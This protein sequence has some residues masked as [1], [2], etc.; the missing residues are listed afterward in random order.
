MTGFFNPQG[1][2]TAMRQVSLYLFFNDRMD[3]LI[4]IYVLYIYHIHIYISVS[5]KLMFV[6]VCV[7]V[8]AV[9]LNFEY[10]SGK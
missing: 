4:Y 3:V 2:L 8:T 6:K 10:V 5:I 9:L 1:F 7:C